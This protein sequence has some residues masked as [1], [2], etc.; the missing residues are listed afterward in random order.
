[1]ILPSYR[2]Y[3]Q[4]INMCNMH[5]HVKTGLHVR[6]KHKHKHKHEHK[7]PTC[8]PVRRKHK[9]LVLAR[10]CA[11]V[12]ACAV[13][14]YTYDA[15]ISTSTKEWKSFHCLVLKLAS[16][17]RACKPKRRKHKHKRKERKLKN[18][19][20]LSAYIL[21]TRALPFSP[22]CWNQI[23]RQKAVRPRDCATFLCF[24]TCVCHLMLISHTCKHP[25]AYAYACVVRVNQG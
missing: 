12:Y 20:K 3:L 23:S 13:P 19:D 16:L 6:R 21:V 17:R 11:C 1:M 25:C 5:L 22:P 9:R 14:V 4:Q 10:G 7:K 2:E 8:K 24:C 15:S 18:C